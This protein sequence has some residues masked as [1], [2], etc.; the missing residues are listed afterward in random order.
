MVTLDVAWRCNS[1][2]ITSVRVEKRRRS[3]R[4]QRSKPSMS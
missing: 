2:T 1:D 4:G 3:R